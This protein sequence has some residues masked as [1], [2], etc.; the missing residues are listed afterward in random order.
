GVAWHQESG[1]VYLADAT[2]QR[3]IRLAERRAGA[4]RGPAGLPDFTGE[5]VAI[6]AAIRRAENDTTRKAELYGRKAALYEERGALE[7]AQAQ[8][9]QALTED[10][11]SMEAME[12][13]DALES[14]LLGRQVT[15]LDEQVRRLLTDFGRETARRDY[16]RTI[17][18]YEQILNLEPGNTGMQRA[19]AAL[20]AAFTERNVP[21][22]PAY[23]LEVAN[24][25]V[26]PLFPVLLQQYRSGGAGAF[27]LANPGD[28]TVEI[29]AVTV[30]VGGFSDGETEI[31]V[32]DLIGP[33]QRVAVDLPVVLNRSALEL[34]EDLAVQV[35]LRVTYAV[36]GEGTW[37][38]DSENRETGGRRGSGPFS[39]SRTV[40]TTIHRR[41]ALIWDDSAKLAS[42]ITPNED[43]VAGFALRVLAA[44]QDAERA[45]AA[46]SANAGSGR[47]PTGIAS[48]SPRMVRAIRLADAMGRYGINYVEDPRSPF[49][50]VHGAEQ[51]VDTVRFP[52]LTLYYRSGDC[53]D[54]SALLASLYEAAGLDTAIVTTPGHVMIAVDTREPVANAWMFETSGT[55]A[56]PYDG[57]LWIPVETTVV[58]RGFATAWQEG[59]QLY[60]RH[61][62]HEEVEIIPTRAARERYSALPLPDASFTIT[63]P[64]T[65]AIAEMVSRSSRDVDEIVYTAGRRNLEERLPQRAG[66]RRI[67]VLNRL[68]ILNARFGYGDRAREYFSEIIELKN[69][70]V[71]AYVNLANLA[72]TGGD[73]E[74]ALVHLDQANRLRPG[75][76]VVLEL[77]A[78]AN[79]IAGNGR[80]ARETVRRLAE[81]DPARAARLSVIVPP[82]GVAAEETSAPGR[83]A[84][85]R[86]SA[87]G[88][89]A[90][91][92][93]PGEWLVEE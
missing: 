82:S 5:I 18:L 29:A 72:L 89:P 31:A 59:T 45:G 52:R 73:A 62:P 84:V 90:A 43:V 46:G 21:D 2:G 49:S 10:P 12:Q 60:R 50:E 41:S 48:V 77:I 22:E 65:H 1:T 80:E 76:P 36:A 33:G 78:R 58:N 8:W 64:P 32:P 70:Y 57:T 67:P 35:T 54:T 19:K 87:A 4:P 6:N 69:D 74:M 9:Q 3:L 25:T 34:Q 85:P 14:R 17:R 42:F 79:F 39:V 55:I 13:I 81:V 91:L 40:T 53:D 71:P 51:A 44:L 61:E 30:S 75:S 37:G 28:Q 93:P 66:S 16:S 88:D 56:I 27:E 86:A 47:I 24:L 15:R 11:F 20:E 23:P 26:E 83:A 7:M 38:E 68:G 63:E 92:L